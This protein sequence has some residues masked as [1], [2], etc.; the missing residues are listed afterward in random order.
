MEQEKV[1]GMDNQ[2]AVQA[3]VE[4]ELRKQQIS[5]PDIRLWLTRL[6]ASESHT[7]RVVITSFPACNS[8]E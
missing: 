7:R 2:A 6:A 1:G 3:A 5:E 4:E 8:D